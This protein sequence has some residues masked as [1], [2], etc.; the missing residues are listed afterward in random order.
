MSGGLYHCKAR[1]NNREGVSNSVRLTVVIPPSETRVT[2]E[3]FPPVAYEGSRLVLCCN[4][5][6]GSH[7]S[8]SWFFNRRPVQ[9]SSSPLVHSQGNHLVIEKVRPEHAGHYSCMAFSTVE[10]IKR[11]SSSREVQLIV[12]VYVTKP[13]ISF[14][15]SKEAGGNLMGNISCSVSRGSPPI[16]FT[17]LLNDRTVDSVTGSGSLSIWFDLLMV[18]GLEMGRAQCR[19]QTEVQDIVSEPLTLEV[20]PVGGHIKVLVDY[21]YRI[22]TKPTAAKLGC[23]ISQ[24]T[25]PFITWLHNGSVLTSDTQTEF[26]IPQTIPPFAFTDHGRTLILTKLGPEVF[27]HYRCKARDSY[28]ESGPWVQSEDVLVQF[29]GYLSPCPKPL[30]P[31]PTAAL[32]NASVPSIESISIA[33]CCF[34][35][36][37]LVVGV[38]CVY[39][40]VDQR[41]DAQ[42]T[43][44]IEYPMSEVPSR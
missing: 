24:G 36:L 22:D 17:L 40:M 34:V 8:Y 3:P 42:G 20:V 23:Q 43:D 5:S 1:A 21:F 2:S 31:P 27:G 25:F 9:S 15:V 10:D 7:L 33:F 13:Q 19:A 4:V 30:P 39:Q 44:P 16:N 6:R 18:P 28:D 38:A 12:K 14:S 29:K 26:Y 37:V 41:R 35:L 11:F 32:P